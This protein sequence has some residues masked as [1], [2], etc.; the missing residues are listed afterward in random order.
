MKAARVTRPRDFPSTIDANE[1]WNIIEQHVPLPL[2]E[3]ERIKTK[4][5][6]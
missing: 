5:A 4:L 6:G 2:A 1:V 3:M